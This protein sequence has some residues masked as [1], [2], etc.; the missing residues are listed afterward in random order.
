MGGVIPKGGGHYDPISLEYGTHPIILNFQWGHP[1]PSFYA[2]LNYKGGPRPHDFYF[3][4]PHG[5]RL[6]RKKSDF[7]VNFPEIW[8]K[9]QNHGVQVT[10]NPGNIQKIFKKYH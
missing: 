6:R 7:F 9:I 10:R 5:G 1:T 3:C 4:G 2:I 8:S